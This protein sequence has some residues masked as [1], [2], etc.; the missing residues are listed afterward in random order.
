MKGRKYLRFEFFPIQKQ[1]GK[2]S[3]ALNENIKEVVELYSET[4]SRKRKKELNKNR[5]P[6][7]DTGRN[8][9]TASMMLLRKAFR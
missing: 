4:F 3:P 6:V 1:N 9:V 8:S 5:C 7:E 2:N